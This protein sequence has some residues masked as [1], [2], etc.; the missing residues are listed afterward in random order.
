VLR[1]PVVEV[2]E[3]VGLDRPRA[4]LRLEQGLAPDGTALRELRRWQGLCVDDLAAAIG[5]SASTVLAWE[6]GR[7]S[8]R[9][10]NERALLDLVQRG[11]GP[12]RTDQA[13]SEPR[14]LAAA[15]A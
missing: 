3:A 13:R 15:M 2:F 14:V 1:V 10:R 8:P 11:F 4:M 6:K 5:V 9:R 12:A 7:Q